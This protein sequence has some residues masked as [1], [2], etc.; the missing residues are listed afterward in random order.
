MLV[1][2]MLEI[3]VYADDPQF[4]VRL[5][6]LGTLK[7]LA[8]AYPTK[9]R[10]ILPTL[11]TLLDDQETRVRELAAGA[12]VPV[13][14]R[15]I[16]GEDDGARLDAAKMLLIIADTEPD[17]IRPAIPELRGLLQ[18]SNQEVRRAITQVLSRS[19]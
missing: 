4:A 14:A 7:Q 5:G 10:A 6:A 16:G 1:G 9:A 15:L 8:A 11:I 2:D 19:R 12:A 3:L 13:L 18:D 17:A